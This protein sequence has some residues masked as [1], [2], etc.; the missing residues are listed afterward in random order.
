MRSSN[1]LA[2][3]CWE[4]IVPFSA[5]KINSPKIAIPALVP[6]IT[7]LRFSTASCIKLSTG[8]PFQ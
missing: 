6:P 4:E 2:N 3:A 1:G 5:L 7:I 8:V